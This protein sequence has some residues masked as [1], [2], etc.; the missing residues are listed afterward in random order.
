MIANNA[1]PWLGRW[2]CGWFGGYQL[3][4]VICRQATLHEKEYTSV[5]PHVKSKTWELN[6][7]KTNL[8]KQGIDDKD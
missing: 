1:F 6:T 5:T 2:G 3:L 8:R 7:I 4:C